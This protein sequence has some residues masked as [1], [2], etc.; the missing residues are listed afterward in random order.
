MIPQGAKNYFSTFLYKTTPP[1]Y[2]N[3]NGSE[4][5]KKKEKVSERIDVQ[6]GP[7]EESLQGYEGPDALLQEAIKMAPRRRGPTRAASRKGGRKAGRASRFCK[8]KKGR[9]FQ[10]C[11]RA[12]FRRH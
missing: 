7:P 8:G 5:K 12:Y 1:I 6:K 11:R 3:K 9:S 10:A 4:E 2:L